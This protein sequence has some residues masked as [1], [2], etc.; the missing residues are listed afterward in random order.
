MDFSGRFSSFLPEDYISISTDA[1]NFHSQ[2][3]IYY[4]ATLKNAM[5]QES[6]DSEPL[7]RISKQANTNRSLENMESLPMDEEVV[8]IITLE[9][10][11]EELL[12]VNVTIFFVLPC[13]CCAVFTCF[14]ND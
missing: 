4:S 7:H 11:M 14:I 12:Q 2:E 10:V 5:Q 8:G 3:S 13:Y 9:D 1:S 6:S